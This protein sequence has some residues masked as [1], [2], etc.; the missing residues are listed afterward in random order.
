MRLPIHQVYLQL[1]RLFNIEQKEYNL[2]KLPFNE[3][4][5]TLTN[6]KEFNIRKEDFIIINPNAS[7]LR[8]ERRWDSEGFVS[9]IN[10]L[11]SKY[12]K[13]FIFLIGSKDEQKYTQSIYD[14]TERTKYIHNLAGKTSINQLIA[15]IGNANAMVT[16]DTGPMHIGFSLNTP[17]VALFGP[18][19][20]IQYGSHPNSISIH[21]NAYCSPCVHEFVIPPCKGNN[22][23][24]KLITVDDVL[25]ATCY[26]LDGKK[27]IPTQNENI[28]FY[29][30]LDT[31][32]VVNRASVK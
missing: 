24:M 1:G 2:Y 9:L 8:V 5:L 20:P 3:N 18:C 28:L 14:R 15:L 7:D 19:L 30:K 4:T 13:L 17:I 31:L 16:N 10:I 25:N 12:P 23:C 26:I 32:G 29:S 22:A 27:Q 6:K 21:K 11:S